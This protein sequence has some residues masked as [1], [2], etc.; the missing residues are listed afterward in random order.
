MPSPDLPLSRLPRELPLVGRAD[1]LERLYTLFGDPSTTEPVAI[2]KGEGGVGK[3]RLARTVADEAG[4]RGW[5]V[6]HGRA[7]P[8]ETGVPYALLS[9]AFLPLLR[10]MDEATLTVLTRGT[11]SEL[12]R[13]FPALGLAEEP[14]IRGEDPAELQSRLYWNFTDLVQRLGSRDPLL[15]VL[16]DLHWADASSLSLL[17]FVA[18]HLS[19]EPVRILCT[20]NTEHRDAQERLVPLERSLVA[21]R[22]IRLLPLNPLTL[23]STTELVETVF[24]ASGRPVREFA[25]I[26]FGWTRGNPYFL[27]QTLDTLVGSG[28][29]Y[30]RDGTWLGWESRELELPASVRDAILLRFRGKPPE[31]LA[32]AEVLAVVGN[33]TNISLLEDVSGLPAARVGRAVDDLVRPGLVEESQE[34]GGIT[35]QF[36]HP[37]TRETLY[38]RLTLTRRRMLHGQVAEALERLH[39]RDALARADEL[40]YHFVQAAS[41]GDESRTVRYLTEAGRAA[42]R[43]H[44][45]REAADYLDAAVSLL[46][47][48]GDADAPPEPPEPSASLD[49]ERGFVTLQH[50][51]ARA[52]ARLGQY[53]EAEEIWQ[54][55]LERVRAEDDPVEVAQA[56]RHLGLIA[57]WTGRH[58]L[59]LERYGRAI[60]VLGEEGAALRARLHV[61]MGLALQELG[62]P[63][64]GRG[65]V[66][67][68]LVIAEELDDT[69]LLGRVHRAL[70][71]L[72]TFTGEA[73]QARRHGWKAV[74]LADEAGDGHVAF[75]GRWALAS[76]EG[77]SGGPPAIEE[78]L[79]Q[80]RA[81]ADDLR[82]P[83]LALWVTELELELAYFSG[84]WE[85]ALAVGER[86]ITRAENLS[87]RTLQ[88]RLMV[89]T[90]TCYLGRG[91][92][93]RGRELVERAWRLAG[94]AGDGDGD[95]PRRHR[96]VHA[97]VPAHIGRTALAIAEGD[98]EEAI[99]I[100]EA[101]MALADRVGYVIWVLHRL[102]PLVGEA[103]V[104]AERLDGAVAVGERLR[105][106]GTRMGH[107]LAL[108]YAETAEAVVTWH[109][110]RV[111]EAVDKL[112]EAAERLEE[113]GVVPEAARVRRHLAARYAELGD[114]QAALAELRTVHEVFGELGARPEL[115]KTREQFREYGSRPPSRAVAVGTAELT[116]REAEVAMHVAGRKSNKAVA[117]ALG[118]S[119]RTVTTHLSN[120]YRKLEIGSRGEL[121]DMVREGRLAVHPEE[122][123]PP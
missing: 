44:A 97:V 107:H 25:E 61:T 77:L 110:G 62:R 71:L 14:P 68:A 91:D 95:A 36:R 117:K 41:A 54:G 103:Y 115:E 8:V 73:E 118:I 32:V 57:F 78:P 99:R 82:S 12:R 119:P 109:S 39:G 69:A 31:A 102:L 116:P 53:T 120:M 92:L 63:E 13:L 24:H 70:A 7:Y 112:R 18:R 45:D 38:Q 29:L 43:R 23:E 27:E 48:D 66:E 87:Q 86:G 89:W 19:G 81:I 55:I 59:A 100:G 15:V 84:D 114:R 75:W 104:R 90:A 49:P 10:E 16:E 79:A 30:N 94:L 83:V 37:L 72:A 1:E 56:H 64:A 3:S 58:E 88:V 46:S 52:R 93:E 65:E 85:R 122:P 111:E 2:L 74:E 26:L 34:G 113:V 105:R 76:L 40:A 17:H 80:A 4:R 108:A 9:D 5:T 51:L 28:R 47:P 33:P 101:G 50:D 42:L 20:Y 22:R 106:E 121:V 35:L 96:D 21:L 67:E 98:Y 60:E 11:Q 123:L 6:I